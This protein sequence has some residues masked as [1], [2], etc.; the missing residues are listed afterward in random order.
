MILWIV[1]KLKPL[2]PENIDLVALKL[3]ETENSYAEWL[4]EDNQ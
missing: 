2:L 4:A 3:H 1:D